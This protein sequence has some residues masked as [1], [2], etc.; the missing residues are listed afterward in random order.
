MPYNCNWSSRLK[1]HDERVVVNKNK[2]RKLE[3]VKSWTFFRF[4][5][6]DPFNSKYAANTLND[7]YRSNGQQTQLLR[8]T[9]AIRNQVSWSK[10][11]SFLK[12]NLH[13][14]M[15]HLKWTA[16]YMAKW[17]VHFHQFV[18]CQWNWFV[19]KLAEKCQS[20]LRYR[21]RISSGERAP[22]TFLVTPWP[23]WIT[24]GLRSDGKLAP[25]LS[26]QLKTGKV[27]SL[28]FPERTL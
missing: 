5:K 19:G 20:G 6:L 7:F 8:F 14:K 22:M 28:K 17:E 24:W 23:A 9:V 21:Y 26:A 1:V 3:S 16:R 2:E 12:N 18:I 15:Y 11:I 10:C 4:T 27:L 13:T 25:S